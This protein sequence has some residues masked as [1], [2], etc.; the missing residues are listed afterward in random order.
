MDRWTL[1]IPDYFPPSPNT[2]IRKHWRVY[3]R[4]RKRA[5]E[6]LHAA[7]LQDG[8]IPKFAGQVGMR[9]VRRWGLGKKGKPKRAMDRD[10]LCGACKPL[11]DAMVKLNIIEN[12]TPDLLAAVYDQERNPEGDTDATWIQVEGTLA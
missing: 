7:C 4:I 8:G 9:I 5:G 1:V 11:I 6:Q 10:N 12:D 3:Y 2:Y